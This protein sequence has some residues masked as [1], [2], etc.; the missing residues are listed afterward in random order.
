MNDN[1]AGALLVGGG[2]MLV[3]AIIGIAVLAFWIWALIDAIKNP[4]LTDNE[5]IIWIIVILLTSWLGALIYLFVG[6]K[7]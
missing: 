4:R 7:K 3:F 1:D 6:R 5:R 2:M